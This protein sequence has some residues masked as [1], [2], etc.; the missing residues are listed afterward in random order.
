MFVHSP[1]VKLRVIAVLLGAFV[2]YMVGMLNPFAV[3][4]AN[5]GAAVLIWI[6]DTFLI[7][8]IGLCYYLWRVA[9]QAPPVVLP[10]P[11]KWDRPNEIPR[12]I[13]IRNS[14]IAV[15]LTAYGTYG[16]YIDDIYVPA[17]HGNG[18][19]LSGVGAWLMY[20]SMLCATAKLVSVVV[21]HYD[22][23]N[24]E[25]AYAHVG[26]AAEWLGWTFFLLALGT[27]F[28]R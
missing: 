28:F 19:H 2:A 4:A 21:D 7:G 25:L 23:R 9:P 10:D 27:M 20:L 13:R 16:L 22:K 8:I 3:Q 24:N 18:A 5:Q 17:K 14:A 26:A 1:V 11:S 12:D 15:M 6:F